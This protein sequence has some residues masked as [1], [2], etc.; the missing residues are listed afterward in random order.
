MTAPHK[1]I[2]QFGDAEVRRKSKANVPLFLREWVSV[3]TQLSLM[4][5]KWNSLTRWIST[6][7]SPPF[8]IFSHWL[9]DFATIAAGQL[10]RNDW[11][12]YRKMLLVHTHQCPLFCWY[13]FNDAWEENENVVVGEMLASNIVDG[14]QKYRNQHKYMEGDKVNTLRISGGEPFTNP[15]L[16]ADIAN[17]FGKQIKDDEAFLWI[18][19]NLIPFQK[20]PSDNINMAL[21]AISK[22]GKS[23]AVHACIHGT[24][25]NSFYRN[26]TKKYSLKHIERAL[27]L[28]LCN[29]IYL[30]PRLNPIGLTPSEVEEAFELLANL[31]GNMPLK[32]YLGPI[33][34]LYEHAIDRMQTFQG[35]SPQF[36]KTIKKLPD[37]RKAAK[38][39]FNPPNAA[40]YIWNKLLE[41]RY[42]VGYAKIPRHV[43]ADIVLFPKT[44]QKNGNKFETEWHNFIF[45]CK[46][47]E[48]EVYARKTLEVLSVPTGFVIEMELENKWI[49]PTFLA[50]AFACPEYYTENNVY[51]LI[52]AAQKDRVPNIIPLRWGRIKRIATADCRNESYSLNVHI[53]MLKY[54]YNFKNRFVTNDHTSVFEYL[55]KYCGA[56]HLPF[57]ESTSYF[58]QYIGIELLQKDKDESSTLNDAAFKSVVLDIVKGKYAPAKSDIYYRIKCIKYEESDEEIRIEEHKLIIQE[59]KTIE[60][61]IE[62]CNPNF[63]NPGYPDV[64]QAGI[65]ISSTVKDKVE[66]APEHLQLSKYGEPSIR[67]K[68]DRSGEFRGELLFEPTKPDARIA[69]FRLPF[70][71]QIRS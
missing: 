34:L 53:E 2:T 36:S 17:E 46:G 29:N 70:V 9:M 6:P 8:D 71:V 24:N 68:F 10:G 12:N 35:K 3:N 13:C 39:S 16:V 37:P 51:V 69:S 63:G 19:T 22:L 21:R 54:A 45:M 52:T 44:S 38:P 66:I 62:E 47:W 43:N 59:G 28:F 64:D 14:F 33:A 20:N 50:H 5:P 56:S 1:I 11:Q 65:T 60:I 48:K 40:M 26:T 58:C 57:S 30:Y 41:Q 4:P 18:D 32:T 25:E 61:F 67:I 15:L 31:E 7:G 49:E 27:K 42:G 23:A 55:A